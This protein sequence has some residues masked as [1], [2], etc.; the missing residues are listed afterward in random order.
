MTRAVSVCPHLP[1]AE[2]TPLEEQVTAGHR[3][4]LARL[5]QPEEGQRERILNSEHAEKTHFVKQ[6][7]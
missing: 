2:T 6:K 4:N 3:T 1:V 5:L 7:G